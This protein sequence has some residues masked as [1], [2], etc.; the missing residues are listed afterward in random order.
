MLEEKNSMNLS[1]LNEMLDEKYGKPGTESRDEFDL[2]AKLWYMG[3]LQKEKDRMDHEEEVNKVKSFLRQRKSSALFVVM[4]EL[5]CT[6]SKYGLSL[7]VARNSTTCYPDYVDLIKKG[8]NDNLDREGFVLISEMFRI[9]G[10][11]LLKAAD[12]IDTAKL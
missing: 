10:R 8:Q 2:R 4:L 9:L 5:V 12:D 6:F 3:E 11:K 7:D 1:T